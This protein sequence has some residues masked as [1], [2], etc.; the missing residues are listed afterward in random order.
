MAIDHARTPERKKAPDDGI[1]VTVDTGSGNGA[2]PT[3]K[4]GL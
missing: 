1:A 3:A 4:G 2:G